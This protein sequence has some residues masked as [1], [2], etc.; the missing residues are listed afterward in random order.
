VWRWAPTARGGGVG[1][2]I[3]DGGSPRRH[4]DGE[5]VQ[6]A[7][8]DGD[9]GFWRARVACNQSDSALQQ[10]VATRRVR[11]LESEKGVDRG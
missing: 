9:G 8:R 10:G 3:G 2:G 6:A 11:H 5:A 4:G 7:V 1:Q